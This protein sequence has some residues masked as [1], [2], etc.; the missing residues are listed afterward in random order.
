M[1]VPA[2][3]LR[4]PCEP[5][6]LHEANERRNYIIC[7]RI[8]VAAVNPD[9]ITRWKLRKSNSIEIIFW[10]ALYLLANSLLSLQ[11]DRV[12]NGDRP[13][14]FFTCLSVCA[15]RTGQTSLSAKC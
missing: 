14:V 1:I 15:R 9:E 7:D 6:T 13:T 8:L 2:W 4:D 5:H 11:S 12:N 3:L 10:P